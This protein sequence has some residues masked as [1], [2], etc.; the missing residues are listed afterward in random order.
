[1]NR[2]SRSRR[3]A[4]LV[5]ITLL[6]GMAA[7]YAFYERTRPTFAPRDPK[8]WRQEVG[9]IAEKGVGESPRASIAALREYFLDNPNVQEPKLRLALASAIIEQ[10]SPDYLF[11]A[12]E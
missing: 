2:L 8:T 5:A 12:H 6:A 10:P 7:V 11:V 9:E 3:I 1:M 4:L